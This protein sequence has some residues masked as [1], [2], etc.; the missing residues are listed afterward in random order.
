METLVE[1]DSGRRPGRPAFEVEIGDRNFEF[2]RIE[3]DDAVV[4]GAQMAIAVGKHPVEDFVVLHQLKSGELESLRSTETAELSR[5][6]TN[7]FF[8]I[9]GGDLNRFYVEGLSMEWPRAKLLAWQVKFLAGAGED[10]SLVLERDGVDQVFDDADEV[11]L[12]GHGA[13][14]FKLRKRKKTVTVI[15]GGDIEFELERRVY[16]TA[17]LI[18]VFGVPAG[19]RLDFI[20]ADGVFREMAPDESLKIRDGMEFGSH[21]PIGQSS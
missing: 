17:E 6:D 19:Y 9:K 2:E 4:T 11:D 15:Y 5:K 21:P 18:A 8:V 16:T 13:E 3:F 12:G 10:K 1:N 7:R 14:R 20:G